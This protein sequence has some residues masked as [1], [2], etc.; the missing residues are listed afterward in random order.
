MEWVAGQIIGL[1]AWIG[2]LILM[3]LMRGVSLFK[4]AR[5]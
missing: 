5:I 2:G 4:R 1:L 3:I